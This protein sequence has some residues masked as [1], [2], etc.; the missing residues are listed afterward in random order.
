MKRPYSSL[1]TSAQ[2]YNEW[3]FGDIEK[4]AR[5]IEDTQKLEI[6]SNMTPVQREDNPCF[7]AVL[8]VTVVPLDIDIHHHPHRPSG[9]RYRS[10]MIPKFERGGGL[11]PP[12]QP[13]M[14]Q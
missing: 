6:K 12:R 11:G 9:K 13:V 5:E 3:L 14:K 7:V 1:C 10:F 2:P 8:S 4:S